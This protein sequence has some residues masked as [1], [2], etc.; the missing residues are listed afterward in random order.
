MLFIVRIFVVYVGG[1]LQNL[2]IGKSWWTKPKILGKF[3][4][5][6]AV[7]VPAGEEIM[8]PMCHECAEEVATE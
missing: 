3:D 2:E 4:I 6:T 7:V 8:V 1:S 5:P